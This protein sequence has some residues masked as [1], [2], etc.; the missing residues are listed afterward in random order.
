MKKKRKKIEI[1]IKTQKSKKIQKPKKFKN[2]EEQEQ[3]QKIQNPEGEGEQE[4]TQKIHTTVTTKPP[5]PNHWDSYPNPLPSHKQP[6]RSIPFNFQRPT[7][8]PRSI[9]F[10]STKLQTHQLNQPNHHWSQPSHHRIQPS[11]PIKSNRPTASQDHPWRATTTPPT[12]THDEPQ[13]SYPQRA[14]TTH[15]QTPDHGDLNPTYPKP[16]CWSMPSRSEARKP[17]LKERRSFQGER[18][19]GDSVGE[20]EKLWKWEEEREWD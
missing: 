15:E 19:R 14:T 1:K 16:P 6:L 9:P 12:A 3:E 5:Y 13:P 10:S 17:I 4:Q 18:K 20:R 8:D 7:Q 11:Q 2:L